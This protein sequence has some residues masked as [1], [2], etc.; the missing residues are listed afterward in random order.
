MKAIILAAGQGKRLLPLTQDTP[1]TLLNISGTTILEYQLVTLASCNVKE[2]VLVGGFRVDKLKD[3][4]DRYIALHGLDLKLKVINNKDYAITNNLYSLWLA[5]DEMTSDFLVI[6]G[7][8]VFDRR[9][10]VKM[11]QQKDITAA[12]AIHKNPGYDDE[13][14]KVRIAGSNVVEISKGID[15][16]AASGESIGLRLFRGKGV[17]AF[18]YAMDLA[19]IEDVKRNAYFVRAIQH[20]I[21]MGHN[22]GYVDVTEFKYGELDFFEDLKNLE[23][24]MSGMMKQSIM[25]HT[26]PASLYAIS[27]QPY[28][29]AGM[30][31]AS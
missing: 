30:K 12:V 5:K 14:M 26:N 18:K 31:K 10:I 23:I 22:V 21:D 1:K 27:L 19:M 7:D 28:R 24:E 4:A 25:M 11:I 6:N 13:D 9:A 2:V 8:N 20:M 29:S 17:A 16:L 3:Y 15:N